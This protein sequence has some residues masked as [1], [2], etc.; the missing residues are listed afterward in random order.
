MLTI[1]RMLKDVYKFKRQNKS[2]Q[3]MFEY[4][5]FFHTFDFP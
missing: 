3:D 2:Y 5:I 1:D 4:W